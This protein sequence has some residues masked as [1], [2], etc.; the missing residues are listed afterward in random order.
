MM[1]ESDRPSMNSIAT[2]VTPPSSMMSKIVTMFGCERAPAAD[3]LAVEAV[4]EFP[5]LG[6]RG[7]DAEGLQGD[8]AADERVEPPVDHAHGAPAQFAEGTVAADG[9]DDRRFSRVG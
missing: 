9:A 4:A 5:G 7:V 8:R 1:A 3:G 2:A 6:V